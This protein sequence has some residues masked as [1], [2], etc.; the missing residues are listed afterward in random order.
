M[1]QFEENNCTD[2]SAQWAQ[3]D[4][5]KDKQVD[6]HSAQQIC[7]GIARGIDASGCLMLETAKGIEKISAG[8]VSMRGHA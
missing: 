3:W 1:A 7:T 8:D 4:V 5:M 2:L 6:I